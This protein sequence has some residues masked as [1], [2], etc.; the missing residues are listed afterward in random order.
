MANLFAA[1]HDGGPGHVH[2]L[3][4][5]F[6]ALYRHSHSTDANLATYREQFKNLTGTPPAMNDYTATEPNRTT[7]ARAQEMGD[8]RAGIVR[9]ARFDAS[10]VIMNALA[11]IIASYGLL[12]D[13]TSGVIG[14]M[15]VA[16]LLGPIVGL[17]LAMVDGDFALLR[18]ASGSLAGGVA[19]VV[20]CSFLIGLLH[21]D[22]PAGKELLARTHPN[23]LDLM[24]ALAGGSVGAYAAVS[25]RVSTAVVGVAIATALVPPLCT[26][27]IFLAR[28]EWENALGGY[29]LTFTNIVAI[30]FASSVVLVLK[31]FHK[32]TDNLR[33]RTRLLWLNGLS[34]GLVVAL[35]VMLT[36]NTK[37]LISDVLYKANVRRVLAAELKQFPGAHLYEFR[38]GR[39]KQAGPTMIR[40]TIGSPTGF[41]PAEVGVLESKLPLPP[42]HS[43]LELR[44]RHV[45]ITVMT[46]NGPLYDANMAKLGEPPEPQ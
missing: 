25:P 4:L 12:A 24:I 18:R 26:G 33:P 10:Y 29:F 22:I 5:A 35:F 40:A 37:T 43:A 41:S 38:I 44:V 14:A 34:L 30:Q 9:D 15:L 2:Q 3:I 36:V 1:C 28:G 32:A 46:R 21:S 17:G 8:I 27:S 42:D 20:L 6:M 11:A 16:M 13:S 19:I 45:H 39:D 7:E 31:G 23:Y